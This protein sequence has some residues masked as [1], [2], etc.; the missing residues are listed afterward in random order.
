VRASGNSINSLH[1]SGRYRNT[2]LIVATQG[3]VLDIAATRPGSG[4]CPRAKG[5]FGIPFDL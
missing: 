2:R 1:T 3:K 5:A 4:I